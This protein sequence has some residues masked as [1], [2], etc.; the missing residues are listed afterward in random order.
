MTTKTKIGD[1]K[2]NIANIIDDPY[3]YAN[4][5]PISDLVD[6]LKQLSHY[7][8]N[9]DDA[10]I[11]DAVY[12]LLRDV[13][14]ERDPTN[15][16]LQEVG[17]PISKDKVQLPYPMASLNKI[18]PTTQILDDWIKNYHG[19]YVLSDKLDGVSGLLWKNNNKFQLFTRGDSTTGQDITHLITYLLKD[20]YKP[21][22]IPNGTAIRGEIIMT[23]KNFEKI[24][25]K[26]KN[27][28][29]TIAGLVNSKNFSIDIAKLTDFVGYSV[30]HP[31]YTQQEQMEKL[32]EWEF[33][34]VKYKISNNLTNDMLSNYLQTRRSNSPYEVDGIVVIDSSKTYDISDINPTYGFAF[35][36]VLSDQVADVKV[37]DIEWNITMHGYLK[38]VVKIEP[39]NLVGVQIKNVTAFNAKYVVDNNLG[40]G[41]IIK[42]VRSG[43]VIP[44]ILQVIKPS[45]TGKPKLPDVPYFWNNTNVDIIV[46]DIHGVAKDAIIIKQ[47]SNFFGVLGVKFISE[48]IVKKLVDHGYKS[49]QDI[50]NTNIGELSKIDGIGETLLRKV[51]DNVRVAF[52]TTNLQTVMTASNTFGRGLGIKKLN[53]IIK[54]YPNI[55]NEKWSNDTLKEKI[56]K[57]PGF[58]E[59]TANQFV[60]GFPKFKDF[61][62]TL[63]KIKIISVKHLKLAQVTAPLSGDL[64]KNMKIVFTGFRSDELENFILSNG[65]NITGT[66]SKNTSLV[67][68][69]ENEKDISAKYIKAKQLNI[70][71]ITKEEFIKKYKK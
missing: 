29:N 45:S 4:N 43:D 7:Y 33:P 16:F 54:E 56:L 14:E 5:V 63:E 58:D 35:K 3:K 59:K 31:K 68:Y 34:V 37:L 10:L 2:K 50:L 11:S 12:D 36:M 6:L 39:V 44:H 1:L 19:P 25:D 20:K 13:L 8:Y 24:K 52:E 15:K 38:P 69:A 60:V 32:K 67:V 55:M 53:I 17:A 9:T 18:K 70:T 71:L 61:F 62:A 51:F 26:Y 30:V 21:G 65:G 23:K 48:G 41:S 46:K 28:R 42:I 22:K 40:P 27:A 64:F 47:I 66:I 49:V 57:L